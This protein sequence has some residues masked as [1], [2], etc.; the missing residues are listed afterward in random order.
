MDTPETGKDQAVQSFL[1]EIKDWDIIGVLPEGLELADGKK[2][3]EIH[4]RRFYSHGTYFSDLRGRSLPDGLRRDYQDTDEDINI[5]SVLP[6]KDG[7]SIVVYRLKWMTKDLGD[8]RYRK[9]GEPADVHFLMSEGAASRLR[10]SVRK[11]T[12]LMDR[13]V[14]AKFP[15]LVRNRQIVP[16]KKLLLCPVDIK[17]PSHMEDNNEI[18]AT[19]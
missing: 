6:Y 11:D 3:R 10:D 9:S 8:P 14:T 1:S 4:K 17:R 19:R 16:W 5:L 18:I 15:E 12:T 7:N 13:I 2:V